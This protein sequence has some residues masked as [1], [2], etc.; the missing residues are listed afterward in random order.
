MK[1]HFKGYY[2]GNK[3]KRV[4]VKVDNFNSF[5]KDQIYLMWVKK[6]SFE[7]GVLKVLPLNHKKIN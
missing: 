3:V 7:S 6:I 4:F 5:E 2:L 1:F